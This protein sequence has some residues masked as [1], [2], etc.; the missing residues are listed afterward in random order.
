M[1]DLRIF[2]KEHSTL[3]DVEVKSHLRFHSF[4]D[5]DTTSPLEK[6]T[7]LKSLIQQF[8]EEG[9]AFDTTYSLILNPNLVAALPVKTSDYI[10]HWKVLKPTFVKVVSKHCPICSAASVRYNGDIDHYRPKSLY[11]W[12]AYEFSNYILLCA[13]CNR[14]YKRAL[15]P[16]V[17]TKSTEETV[18]INDE[19]PLIINPLIDNPFDYFKL[20]LLSKGGSSVTNNMRIWLVP[21]SFDE[22]SYEYKRA[23]ATI[24]IF[25]LDNSRA[26]KNNYSDRIILSR[27]VYNSL[28]DLAYKK[29]RYDAN[30]NPKSSKQY[31]NQIK[32][33]KENHGGSWLQFVLEGKFEII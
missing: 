10:N 6:I 33:T 4:D 3:T 27:K 12:L 21:S 15:F 11:K 2:R 24:E 28:M 31:I 20:K 13:D 29:I 14:A 17:G 30:K 19:Q 9:A 1:K 8:Q 26:D 16:I 23:I 18:N 5:D 22:T 25:N 32:K 7:A